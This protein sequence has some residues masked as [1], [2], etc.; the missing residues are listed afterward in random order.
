LSIIIKS[1]LFKKK[2]I[3]DL[4]NKKIF[5]SFNGLSIIGRLVFLS[6]LI[7][8]PPCWINVPKP[9]GVK[10]AGI[11]A[12]PARIFSAKVPYKISNKSLKKSIK[13]ILYLWR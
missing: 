1:N 9:V 5:T 10:K 3:S 2:R 8:A 11:P 6:Y 4:I 13:L 12:P 7:G